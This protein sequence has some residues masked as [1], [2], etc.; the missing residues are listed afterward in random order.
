MATK[1]AKPSD[2]PKGG[3]RQIKQ[4][5]VWEDEDVT[6]TDRGNN[7]NRLTLTNTGDLS[8]TINGETEEVDSV[9]VVFIRQHPHFVRYEGS[10]APGVNNPPV[11]VSTDGI[12]GNGDPGGK[13]ATCAFV[14]KKGTNMPGR[15]KQNR[16]VWALPV[17]AEY[18]GV[19]PV[20]VQVPYLSKRQALDPYTSGLR[21]DGLDS[22]SVVTR[23]SA[24]SGKSRKR[25]KVPGF[26]FE[27][28]EAAPKSLKPA[29]DECRRALEGIED[30]LLPALGEG[31]D[32]NGE[33]R[34]PR[35][36]AQGGAPDRE[37]PARKKPRSTF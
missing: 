19:G 11:C 9:D 8:L 12:T 10:Y 18:E 13:C 21:V 33:P 14:D 23:I 26:N 29:L 36:I 24:G 1:K 32:D 2:S 7:F 16:S 30:T 6:P 3:R 35:Q 28:I 27:A 25:G 31:T 34:P 22:R 20:Q 17:G 37:R 5:I 15:C 4:E